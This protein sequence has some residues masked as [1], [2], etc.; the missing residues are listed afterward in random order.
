MDSALSDLGVTEDAT[1]LLFNGSL[2]A[3]GA[4]ALPFAWWYTARTETRAGTA[5]G[6]VFAASAVCMAGVGA[7][8][9]D[10][11][12]HLPMAVGF[13]LSLTYALALDASD[14]VLVGDRWR[15]LTWFWAVLGHVSLWLLWAVVAAVW[16]LS[17]L[18]V[19]EAG[20]ALVLAAWVVTTARERR[21][22]SR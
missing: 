17:A 10:T 22:P 11:A 5:A 16:S 20:G 6:V 1:A 13:Y 19:P 14:A 12:L 15:A 4:L 2:I 9:S 7:F 18:A 8:P 3:A 21:L